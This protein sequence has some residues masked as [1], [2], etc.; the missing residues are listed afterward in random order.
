MKKIISFFLLICV[1]LSLYSYVFLGAQS[2][3]FEEAFTSTL[4]F[5]T[6]IGSIFEPLRN[7]T[8]YARYAVEFIQTLF[9]FGVTTVQKVINVI[10]DLPGTIGGFITEAVSDLGDFFT[11]LGNRI[12]DFFTTL[13]DRI[14][15]FFTNIFDSIIDFFGGGSGYEEPVGPCQYC[16]NPQP[17]GCFDLCGVC[18]KINA[19][20]ECIGGVPGGDD[21]G[22]SNVIK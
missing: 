13:G 8:E 11:T 21:S 2:F 19:L 15:G 10:T 4:T 1:V 6:N 16:G 3:S 14:S 5:L 12:S 7:I 18:G 20:C 9:D 22:G 17:C